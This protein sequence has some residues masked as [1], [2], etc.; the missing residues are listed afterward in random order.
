VSQ[1]TQPE[2]MAMMLRALKVP[3]IASHYVEVG[4]RAARDGWS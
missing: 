2:T 3:A 1:T 4:S